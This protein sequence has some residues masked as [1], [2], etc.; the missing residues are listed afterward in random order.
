[1]GVPEPVRQFNKPA[2]IPQTSD[3]SSIIIIISAIVIITLAFCLYR[4][5]KPKAPDDNLSEKSEDPLTREDHLF[6]SAYASA[7]LPEVTIISPGSTPTNKAESP[8]KINYS[9]DKVLEST[10]MFVSSDRGFM[11]TLRS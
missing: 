7:P 11:S 3:N 2:E 9:S 10:T 6:L 4:R 8:L 5:R 1:M